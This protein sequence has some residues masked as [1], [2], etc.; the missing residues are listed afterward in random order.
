[1]MSDLSH[2]LNPTSFPLL[3]HFHFLM[4]LIFSSLC[5]HLFIGII[6][7]F[8][9]QA[10]FEQGKDLYS[11]CNCLHSVITLVISHYLYKSSLCLHTWA[12]IN[13]LWL[14]EVTFVWVCWGVRGFLGIVQQLANAKSILCKIIK[15]GKKVI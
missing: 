8:G 7:N 15:Y 11:S 5:W 4:N 10:V 3:S 2:G 12:T 14:D 13:S 1:M 9:L 6:I